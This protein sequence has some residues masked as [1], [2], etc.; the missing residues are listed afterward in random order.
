MGNMT[1]PPFVPPVLP[2]LIGQRVSRTP[3]GSSNLEMEGQ[4]GRKEGVSCLG[5]NS[6]NHLRW[7]LESALLK[8]ELSE[9]LVIS[10][11]LLPE[12]RSN[13]QGFSVQGNYSELFLE[14]QIGVC[15]EKLATHLRTI[16]HLF[17]FLR[18][19]SIICSSHIILFMLK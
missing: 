11:I 9:R 4:G 1:L 17:C 7:S 6:V 18:R 14:A 5:L 2:S 3:V 15:Q 13:R 19:S 16:I 10:P 12:E 8:L